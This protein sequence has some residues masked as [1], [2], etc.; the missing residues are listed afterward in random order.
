MGRDARVGGR[1]DWWNGLGSHS[2]G[3]RTYVIND[4]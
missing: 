4:D 1:V 3:V 2:A